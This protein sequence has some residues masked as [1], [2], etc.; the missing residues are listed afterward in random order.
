MILTF[1]VIATFLS[2][3]D[4]MWNISNPR[5]NPSKPY[6]YLKWEEKDFYSYKIKGEWVLRQYRKTDSPLKKRIR[7][8]YWKKRL[9]K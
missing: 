2:F 3:S 6:F 7:S 1:Y 4:E 5:P 8:K 9:G